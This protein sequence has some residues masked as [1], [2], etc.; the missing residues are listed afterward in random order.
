M[1]TM[2]T[3]RLVNA[4]LALCLAGSLRAQDFTWMKGTNQLDQPGI[5]G[6]LGVSA[7]ANAPGSR[8]DAVSWK[9]A[10]GNLWMFGGLGTDING[11]QDWLNDLWKYDP[12]SNQWTWV[13]GDNTVNQPAVYGTQGVA[14]P[15]NKPG[16]R[17]RAMGWTDN[18]GNLWMFGGWF[19][20]AMYND[21][22]YNDL[23]KYNIATNQWTWMKGSSLA[24]QNGAYGII[25]Q[26]SASGNPGCRYDAAGWVDASGNFWL[27]GGI[28]FDQFNSQQAYLND[29]WRYNPATNQWTWMKGSSTVDQFGTYGTMN[30]AAAAN[31]PG[32][33]VSS[34]GVSDA[35]GNLWLF[36][37]FGYDN[38]TPTLGEQSDLWRYNVNTNQ[39]TWVSGNNVIDQTGLYG[40]QGQPAPGNQPGGRESHA[41]WADLNGNLWIFGGFGFDANSNFPNQ[42][43]DLWKY[44]TSTSQWTWV[45]GSNQQTQT[46]VYGTQGV[47]SPANVPGAR[48]TNI[49]WIDGSNNLW[50]FGGVGY[51]FQSYGEFNDL[52][53]FSTCPAAAS[54]TVST[55]SSLLCAG[56]SATLSAAGAISYT[57]SNSQSTSSIVVSPGTTTV[58]FLLSTGS[59]GC[60]S[61]SSI[62]QSVGPVPSL[63]VTSSKSLICRGEKVQLS[64][65]GA[66]SYSWHTTPATSSSTLQVSPIASTNYTVSGFGANG[67]KS[68]ALF[69][70]SVSACT[71]LPREQSSAAELRLY[72]N[73]SNGE[74]YLSGTFNDSEQIML[75][76]VNATGMVVQEQEFDPQTPLVRTNL[77]PGLYYCQVM[78]GR[79]T[80]RSLKLVVR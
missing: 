49:N 61:S 45:K 3:I 50:L 42:L 41:M 55:S 67:C 63:S 34:R 36:G 39:W 5:Y 53:K 68:T 7:A 35:A 51:S 73:P 43:N 12:I 24:N 46:G 29:L 30:V 57:W 38:S 64:V 4:L 33:R 75:R 71:G 31:T 14:S 74:F 52:W 13:K 27:F 26:S 37:G 15:A 69:T 70:Q 23:W 16:G 22:L 21:Y 78:Q 65:A 19:L 48:T 79:G 59:N 10:A 77:S 62:T 66:P 17:G 11:T 76:I 6:T 60:N 20:D 40:T 72:P 9:D 2:K 44:S 58:Y 54:V 18:Q 28:G 80:L 25:T 8:W 56:G 1:K 32:G 47:A